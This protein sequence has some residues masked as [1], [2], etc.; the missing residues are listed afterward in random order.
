MN[1]F[2]LV[3]F[4]TGVLQFSPYINR[5]SFVFAGFIV[6]GIAGERNEKVEIS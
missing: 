4:L 5:L 3:N 2:I 1:L 6:A